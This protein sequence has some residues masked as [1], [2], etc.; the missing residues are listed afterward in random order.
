M[1]NQINDEL[2]LRGTVFC[3]RIHIDARL[4]TSWAKNGHRSRSLTCENV[5]AEVHEQKQVHV[6]AEREQE[7][8]VAILSC[9][10]RTPRAIIILCRAYRDFLLKNIVSHANLRGHKVSGIGLCMMA[11]VSEFPE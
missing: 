4:R 1:K 6:L 11:E 7:L 3:I 2:Q 5:E 9:T 8:A 10:I